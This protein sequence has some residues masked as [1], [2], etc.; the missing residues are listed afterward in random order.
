MFSLILIS[1]ITVSSCALG[2]IVLLNNKKSRL[3]QLFFIFAQ[4]NTLWAF[5]NLMTGIDP[6]K[7]WVRGMYGFGALLMVSGLIWFFCLMDGKVSKI[8]YFFLYT[9]GVIFFFLSLYTKLI[10]KHIN[11]IHFGYFD[12]E[13]G[14]AFPFY[15][16]FV[17]CSLLYIVFRLFRSSF[18]STGFRKMQL[19]YVAIGALIFSFF[20]AV[21]SFVLPILNILFFSQFDLLGSFIFLVII[22]YSIVK[23]RLMDIR[24][25]ISRSIL[26]FIL[27]LFV[28]LSFTFVTFSTAQFF[29]GSGQVAVTLAVSLIIVIFLDPLKRL[30]AKWTDKFFYKGKINYQDVLRTTGQIIASEIDLEKLLTVLTAELEKCVKLSKINILIAKNG[31][32]TGYKS[33]DASRFAGL[34]GDGLIA[35]Y[36]TE[37]KK[38]IVA[39]ELPRRRSELKDPSQIELLSK[40]EA[41]LDELKIALAVPILVE[42]RMTGMFLAEGKMSGGAFTQ[43]DLNFFEVLS[44][45]VATALEKAKLFEEV[46][47]AKEN[48]EQLV[49][50]RT[51]DL[52]ERNRYL[53]AMQTLINLITRSLDFGKVM[54][55]IADGIHDELNFIGGI[56]S[57]INE[58]KEIVKIGSITNTPAIRQI[59]SLIP[60]DPKSYYIALTD[61]ENIAIRAI[62]EQKIIIGKSFYDVVKPAVPEALANMV[63]KRL[64]VKTV[65]AVPVYS[66]SEVIGVIDFALEKTETEI[67]KVDMEMMKSL[68]DQVGIV[69]RNISFYQQIQTAN[70]DL[71]SANVRLTQLDHAKSEFLSIASHQ[72]R[73]PLTGIKGYLSMILEGDYGIIPEKMKHVIADVFQASDRLTRLVN[74]FL[75]VSKIESGKFELSK[76]PSDLIIL[77]E[78]VV[79]ELKLAAENKHLALIFNKPKKLIPLLNIDADKIKDVI[80]NLVDNAIKYTQQGKIEIKAELIG[81]AVQVSV[82]DTGIGMN[83]RDASELFKKFVRGEGIAQVNTDGSGLGLF[84]A[85]KIVEAHSGKIWVE[86]AGKDMGSSFIFTLPID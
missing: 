79:K 15:T 56:L 31:Q 11:G 76:K 16:F 58:K 68:S 19:T 44:P 32:F 69:Y 37:H 74:V 18:K 72:L 48:L 47:S 82:K 14:I 29:E 3:N 61:Q 35:S 30:L 75:N 66:E 62:K 1:F 22:T 13:F 34:T 52:Q 67:S 77:I 40:L 80:L 71:Q 73:T 84:I 23:Y 42:E 36:L 33:L 38:A 63:Q 46:Q 9:T 12:G 70:R 85:K 53:S 83:Q 49:E 57:F 4:T 21:L 28:A 41:R 86:S 27:V 7:I 43:E 6:Q 64:G 8:K 5:V 20:T 25:I 59:I 78:N 54:Q 17:L 60:K 2:F 81:I 10:I 39:E 24:L 55:T 26:Y 65:V 45:Q 51:Y 50:R